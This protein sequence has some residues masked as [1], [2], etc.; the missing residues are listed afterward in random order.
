[1]ILRIAC[2]WLLLITSCRGYAQNEMSLN[3]TWRFALAATEE[4]ATQMAG[5]YKPEFNTQLFKPIPV[6]SNWAVL[7]Y[8]EPV[9]RGFEGNKASEGF[10]LRQFTVPP[11]WKERRLL[12]HFGGVWSSAEV[13]VNGRVVGVHHGGYNSFA[14]DVTDKV[15]T[16]TVNQLAVRVRQVSA[17]YKFDVFD[18]W[19]LGGIYR[20][21]TLESMP[22]KRCIDHVVATTDFDGLFQDGELTIKTMVSDKH[23]ETLPG[24]YASPGVPYRLRFTLLTR[25]GKEACRQELTIQAHTSTD[26]YVAT[27][28]R[29]ATPQ[30]WTAETPNLY[31]L[32]VD[33]L[34]ENKVTH[35]RTQWIGFRKITTQGG[36]LSINGQAVKL[37]G[38]NRHDEHPDV[39]RATTRQ[40]W[41]Q[42]LLLMKAAN[43]NYIRMAHYP[44]AEGFVALCDSL[45]MYVG[46]E[47]SLGGAG[48]LMYDPSFS[49]AVLQRSYETVAR[50]INHPSVI[51]WSIGNEDPFT[52]LHSASIKLVK[53]LD[54]TRPVLLPWRSEE[55]LPE[56]VD[57]LAPHYWKPQ[58]YDQL[59][60]QATRPVISTEY[61]HAFGV[62]GFGGLEACWKALTKHAAG[63]G[64][65][66]WMWADQGI[67]TPVARPGKASALSGG[68]NHLR[69]DEAGWDGIVDSY[70]NTTRD[71][72]EAKAVY[73]QVC[74]VVDKVAFTPGQASVTIGIQNDFDFTNLQGVKIAWSVY[75]DE[76]LLASGV[77][78]IEG[79][80]HT[81]SFLRLPL[82]KLTACKAGKTY[83]ARLVFTQADGTEITRKGVEL[84]P[85]L[86]P[87]PQ[88]RQVAGD[89][90]VI[91]KG[92]SVAIEAGQARYVFHA[93]TGQLV[94]AALEHK[95]LITDLRPVIWH[96]PDRAEVSVIGKK[97]VVA[98]G[99]LNRY[100][101]SVKSWA[102]SKGLVEVVID[103]VVEYVIDTKNRFTTTYRYTIH[104]NG[105]MQVHYKI[106][107]A[108][109]VPCIPV[110]GMAIQSSPELNQL[111]WLGLGPY[112]AWPNKQSAPVLGV[113]GGLASGE[114]THG[115]KAM[116]WLEQ[117]DATAGIRIF[118][119]GYLEHKADKPETVYVLSGV[120]G[121]PEKGRK[122]DASV[123]QLRT[124]THEPFA[125]AL[126]M[127]LFKK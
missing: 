102:V 48:N 100:K 21:V 8:E 41:L 3:G 20:D 47:V 74:P 88:S 26:R 22:S 90:R 52:T 106:I 45:G 36:V 35:S 127:E 117:R 54:P 85:L 53:A 46:E 67:K 13:W 103:A 58:E 10:Y 50:D 44:P 5:F 118:N 16:D 115:T 120:L 30:H 94:S 82:D 12:L 32:R 39:G 17:D 73:A 15:R 81:V 28:M 9:Y 42:D 38:V 110:V 83:Y 55:W 89:I 80:P 97:A 24:N 40:Q 33:L 14:F 79:K 107:T 109:S 75:E 123:P 43:I 116:R 104:G 34:E 111:R 76:I 4:E 119:N 86:Q 57:M 71:Y 29:V 78:S 27:T 7:G 66:I 37:R 61:T 11:Q 96:T 25:E 6:P 70:R 64:A 108:V 62:D 72:W 84:S 65:A 19:T 60:G 101:P 91:E 49:G 92:D 93:K 31:Q 126:R 23:K 98:A 1:M 87:L 112:D 59:A 99:D 63:A 114:E 56:E 121:R 68:D 69:I 2:T 122:A 113:W 18:D 124:D 105:S 95:K 77:A 125:G 51:Y